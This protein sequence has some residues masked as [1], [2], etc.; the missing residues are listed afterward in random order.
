[1]GEFARSPV[2]IPLAGLSYGHEHHEPG[3]GPTPRCAARCRI[4]P[5]HGHLALS[6]RSPS[7]A[8]AVGTDTT[9][10]RRGFRRDGDD[11]AV[12]GG[13]SNRTPGRKTPRLRAVPRGPGPVNARAAHTTPRQPEARRDGGRGDAA[14]C[15]TH[16]RRPPRTACARSRVAA[17][18]AQAATGCRRHRSVERIRALDGD[19]PDS[20]NRRPLA[21]S[22][23][24]CS[25]VSAGGVCDTRPRHGVS[26]GSVLPRRKFDGAALTAV[27]GDTGHRRCPATSPHC[28]SRSGRRTCCAV[29][30]LR[31]PGRVRRYAGTAP[32]S[33]CPGGRPAA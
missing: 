6:L 33:A 12:L 23:H 5:G 24:C 3:S 13:G 19:S 22:S 32:A 1:M 21:D 26:G 8:R 18:R 9:S 20:L 31:S 30:C 10:G 11:R 27:A 2:R 4:P 14:R 29:R 28:R 25:G 7:P 17:P 15:G 16:D